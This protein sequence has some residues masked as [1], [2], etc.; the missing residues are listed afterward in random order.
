[1]KL[2]CGL[3][4]FVN[5]FADKFHSANLIAGS[6]PPKICYDINFHLAHFFGPRRTYTNT[7]IHRDRNIA[8]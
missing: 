5:I 1:M 6:F 4:I 8:K 3:T 7:R 2:G